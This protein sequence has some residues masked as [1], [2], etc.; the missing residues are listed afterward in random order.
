[1]PTAL[2]PRAKALLADLEAELRPQASTSA[3]PSRKV[4]AAK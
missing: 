3:E 2:S 4:A 1:V